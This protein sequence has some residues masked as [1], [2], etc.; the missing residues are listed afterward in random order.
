[1]GYVNADGAD[2]TGSRIG[3]RVEG[4]AVVTV[5][6]AIFH[7]NE[8]SILA[9]GGVEREVQKLLQLPVTPESK[10]IAQQLAALNSLPEQSRAAIAEQS[11]LFTNLRTAAVDGTTIVANLAT[12]WPAILPWVT[13]ALTS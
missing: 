13:Q 11:G 9:I 6:N 5:R 7:Q 1:M 12:I 3:V 8:I 10:E 2:F 4:E